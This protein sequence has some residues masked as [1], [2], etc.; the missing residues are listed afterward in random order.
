M[1]PEQCLGGALDRRSDV[2][3]LG[4]VLFELATARRLFKRRSTYDT[5]TAIT[6]ADVPSPRRLNSKIHP[7]VEQ[8]I[9]RSLQRQADDRFPTC[10]DM[11]DALD[12]AMREAGLRGTPTDLGRFMAATFEEEQAQQQRLLQQAQRGELGA[13]AEAAQLSAVAAAAVMESQVNYV[14][15]SEEERTSV[16]LLPPLAEDSGRKPK[17]APGPGDPE[18]DAEEEIMTKAIPPKS[19]TVTTEPMGV[20][21]IANAGPMP[22]IYYAFAVLAVLLIVLIAWLIAR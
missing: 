6:T 20:K 9:V 21:V 11:H 16:D 17:V 8:V 4:I 22:T 7:A 10:D 15:V 18:W 13:G 12:V 3:S 5:Y 1:S 2:F 14:A 19:S